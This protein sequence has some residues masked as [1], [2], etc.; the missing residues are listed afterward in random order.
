MCCPPCPDPR[1]SL[2][3]FYDNHIAGI[4]SSIKWTK[5][6]LSLVLNTGD[7]YIK[8]VSGQL[9]WMKGPNSASDADPGRQHETKTSHLPDKSIKAAHIIQ[10]EGSAATQPNACRGLWKVLVTGSFCVVKMS[11]LSS[12]WLLSGPTNPVSPSTSDPCL[13]GDSYLTVSWRWKNTVQPG[14]VLR[15]GKCWNT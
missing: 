1:L 6:I 10:K 12:Y 13:N 8:F 4:P 11:F 5:L 7:E 14:S 3:F 15:K 2:F 9:N